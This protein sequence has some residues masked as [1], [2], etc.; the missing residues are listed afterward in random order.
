MGSSLRLYLGSERG[1]PDKRDGVEGDGSGTEDLSPKD[2]D[3]SQTLRSSP[4]LTQSKGMT[5]VSPRRLR[6]TRVVAK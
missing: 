5:S 6:G 2:P 4:V 3:A 1:R